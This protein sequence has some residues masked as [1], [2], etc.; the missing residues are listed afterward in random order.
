MVSPLCP[1]KGS[2]I[3]VNC[4]NGIVRN[5]F[6]NGDE[7]NPV[8]E[9]AFVKCLFRGQPAEFHRWK[10]LAPHTVAS[11]SEMLNQE[12]ALLR[13]ALETR[14]LEFQRGL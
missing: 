6:V 9:I 3:R 14:L 12:I 11:S 7:N 8:L 5:V 13:T 1:P 4:W 2:Y 10:D